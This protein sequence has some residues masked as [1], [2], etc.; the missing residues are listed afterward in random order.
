MKLVAKLFSSE[1]KIFSCVTVFFLSFLGLLLVAPFLLSVGMVGLK[2]LREF[3]I[4]LLIGSVFYLGLLVLFFVRFQAVRN[5]RG[6]IFLGWLL[7]FSIVSKGLVIWLFSSQYVLTQDYA[8]MQQF[9]NFFVAEGA[10]SVNLHHFY[11][12]R[13]FV[14]RSFPFFWPME[15]LF[16]EHD[17]VAVQI[18]NI[19]LETG[20]LLLVFLLLAGIVEEHT[21]RITVSLLA[22][23]PL[24][25]WEVLNYTHDIPGTFLFLSCLLIIKAIWL[26]PDGKK[27]VLYGVLFGV[28]LFA[29]KLQR[30]LHQ[31]VLICLM[32]LFFLQFIKKKAGWTGKRYLILAVGLVV[33]P[34]IIYLPSAKWFDAFKDAHQVVQLKGG[35]ASFMARGWNM[36]SLG[37]YNWLY[38]GIDIATPKSEKDRVQKRII[39]SQVRYNPL[40]II[41][42]L[43]L[44][45]SAKFFMAGYASCVGDNLR[46]GGQETAADI[47]KATRIVFT[48]FLLG[49]SLIGVFYFIRRKEGNV[50]LLWLCAMPLIA[51]VVLVF[52]GEVSPRY[53][54]FFHFVL[55]L[56][57]AEGI[58][59]CCDRKVEGQFISVAAGIRV[60]AVSGIIVLLCYA[61]LAGALLVAVES[62]GND[63]V[64]E[65][66]R[67]AELTSASVGG[68]VEMELSPGETLQP[69]EQWI[70]LP[71][72][73]VQTGASFSGE[74]AIPSSS[75]GN[76]S[77]TFYLYSPVL[78]KIPGDYF[79]CTISIDGTVEET[80]SLQDLNYRK[81]VVRFSKTKEKSG[82]EP[83]VIN[84]AIVYRGLQPI[85]L[86]EETLAL[87]WGYLSLAPVAGT[88]AEK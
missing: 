46:A 55:C 86:D 70:V 76:Y 71:K 88:H 56:L 38:E 33:L 68:G 53:S 54:Y 2:F 42:L 11:D 72:G 64:F 26:H 10:D 27:V 13:A 60:V 62:W 12:W 7:S 24:H 37:E 19:L 77:I 61:V 36:E 52:L 20:S 17:L 3:S 39:V 44:V 75:S 15:F 43:P 67:N 83:M 35:K 28:L 51:C 73:T 63:Y 81:Q 25:T 57:A 40:E 80:Y 30:G 58:L 74:L 9:V 6:P 69:F 5:S 21:R 47:V 4:S 34:M 66:M 65:D 32:V 14:N 78:K 8:L 82:S 45:K 29:L 87:R 79:V 84:V 22:L 31:F 1:A 16:G 59:Y 49:F 23:F 41:G 18:A 85:A 48:P 50:L